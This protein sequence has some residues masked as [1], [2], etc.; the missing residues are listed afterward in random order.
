M[1]ADDVARG[2]TITR[3]EGLADPDPAVRLAAW[4]NLARQHITVEHCMSLARNGF[5]ELAA[6]LMR[7]RGDLPDEQ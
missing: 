2:E 5:P 4:H 6:E 7:Q 1:T 3:S